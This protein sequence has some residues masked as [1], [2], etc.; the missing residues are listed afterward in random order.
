MALA[1]SGPGIGRLLPA[2]AWLRGR[3]RPIR[4]R[5]CRAGEYLSSAA[6]CSACH[7]SDAEQALR[8]QRARS[9]RNSARCIRR[10]ITPDPATGHRQ[11]DRSP[12]SR[13]RCGSAGA[14][15]ASICTRRCPTPTS[16]RSPTPTCTRSGST[17]APSSRSPRSRRPNQMKF[18]FNVRPGIAAWQA[19]YFR[20]GR[21]V[22]DTSQSAAVEPGRLPG[23]GSRPLR[24][25]PHAEEFR[26]GRQGR[27]RHCKARRPATTGSRRTSAAAASPGSG[28][29]ARTRS[30]RT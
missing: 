2:A 18:P 24:R 19:V 9:S 29:G 21:Y 17:S 11:L 8:W 6:H 4:P 12:S 3:R 23:R 7:T 27:A 22:A 15:T 16:R 28:T 30:S 10:N 13:P 1:C 20:P 5:P 25:L 14:S 26:D